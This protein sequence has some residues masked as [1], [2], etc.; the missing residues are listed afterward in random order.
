MTARL[1]LTITD[2]DYRAL[3]D[4]AQ[5][6]G[7]PVP[8]IIAKAVHRY[9]HGVSNPVNQDRG[10]LSAFSTIVP[11]RPLLEWVTVVDPEVVH[12]SAH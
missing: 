4:E 12:E 6:T 10:N 3:W 9:V 1:V 2:P 5:S 8:A 11:S 7:R